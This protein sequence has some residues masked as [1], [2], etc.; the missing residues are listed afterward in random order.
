MTPDFS[1]FV[2]LE[3]ARVQR[4]ARNRGRDPRPMTTLRQ[5]GTFYASL[6]SCLGGARVGD[7]A[8]EVTMPGTRARFESSLV[9]AVLSLA[10]ASPAVALTLQLSRADLCELSARVVV[11]RVSAQEAV[12]DPGGDFAIVTRVDLAV[13]R[14]VKGPAVERLTLTLP[15][16]EVG[17]RG[18]WVED[19]PRLDDKER[20]LLFLHPWARGR[21]GTLG[22]EGGAVLLARPPDARGEAESAVISSLGRCGR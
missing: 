4:I 10:G 8:R 5:I 7:W 9:F 17:G 6:S 20:Y 13:E 1:S 14:V 19:V 22:G 11:A 21:W 15:G 18:V 16:G 2:P 12:L 3:R